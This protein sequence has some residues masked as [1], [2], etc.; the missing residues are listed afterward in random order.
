M[1]GQTGIPR[2][3]LHKH[4]GEH[5]NS[6]QK[7]PAPEGFK[8]RTIATTAPSC[9]QCIWFNCCYYFQG[10]VRVCGR[11]LANE[12]KQNM[13]TTKTLPQI[14]VYPQWCLMMYSPPVKLV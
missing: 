14:D 5:A 1:V 7:S 4:R 10:R 3:N 12:T 11:M 9:C 13:N 2:G 6:T 8:A